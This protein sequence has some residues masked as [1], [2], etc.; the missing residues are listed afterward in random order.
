MR[1]A[2][3]DGSCA[4]SDRYGYYLNSRPQE[5]V[6]V[7]VHEPSQ[8]LGNYI[9]GVREEGFKAMLEIGVE[10]AATRAEFDGV[11]RRLLQAINATDVTE[12]DPYA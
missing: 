7:R 3:G 4:I 9:A 2:H 8:F 5:R 11:V 6:Q 1:L 12:I 10:G